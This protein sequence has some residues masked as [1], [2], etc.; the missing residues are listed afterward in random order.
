M[1]SGGNFFVAFTPAMRGCAAIVPVKQTL[2]ASIAAVLTASGA[3]L[4][5]LRA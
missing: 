2:C 1:R 4:P 5:V 3:Y